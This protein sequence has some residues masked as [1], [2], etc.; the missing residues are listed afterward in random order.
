MVRS[1]LSKVMWVGTATVFVVG[2]AVVL[3]VV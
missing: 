2:L 3:A 1:A